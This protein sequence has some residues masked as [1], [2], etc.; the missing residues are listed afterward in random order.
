[1]NYKNEEINKIRD[2]IY[3]FLHFDKLICH[4]LSE[5]YGGSDMVLE[6]KLYY[7]NEKVIFQIKGNNLE[8]VWDDSHSVRYN[9]IKELT[10]I[11]HQYKKKGHC[12]I[13]IKGQLLEFTNCSNNIIE[14]HNWNYY[15]KNLDFAFVDCHNLK[16]V[17]DF[18]P[19]N[20]NSVA[21]IFSGCNSFDSDL[22][23]W[24][25]Y[26]IQNTRHMFHSCFNFNSDL[27]EWDVSNIKDMKYMFAECSEFNSDISKWIV[28]DVEDME[29]MFE[30]CHKFNFDLSKWNVSKCKKKFAIYRRCNIEKK[31]KPKFKN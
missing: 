10:I 29:S 8:I 19:K 23:K 26:N 1:M 2:H 17:P 30:G 24:D 15:L 22:S 20:V 31:Y 6:F 7:N 18:I 27:S 4:V 9:E 3:E 12:I 14:V 11:E 25:V 5:Y 13:R 28:S 16:N 21:H